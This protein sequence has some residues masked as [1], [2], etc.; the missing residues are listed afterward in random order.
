MKDLLDWY[1]RTITECTRTTSVRKGLTAVLLLVVTSAWA[2]EVVP[3]LRE[4]E[5]FLRWDSLVPLPLEVQPGTELWQVGPTVSVDWGPMTDDERESLA[6]RLDLVW[7]PLGRS[8]HPALASEAPTLR[9]RNL[10]S[11]AETVYRI[12]VSKAGVLIEGARA[13]DRYHAL[14]TLGQLLPVSARGRDSVTVLEGQLRDTAAWGWRGLML[15]SSRH[16][17]SVETVEWVLEL[18]ARHKLNR[19]HW[20]LTDDQGWRLPVPGW[21]LLT[22]VGGWRTVDGAPYGGF[23]TADEI[24]RVVAFAARRHIVVV[25]EVDL[26]GHASAA[27]AAYP[28]LSATGAP[29]SVPTEWG[30]ADGVL[31]IGRASVS[32]F[33]TDVLAALV[34]LFPGPWI[35]WGGDEVYR[36]PFLRNAES[37]AWMKKVKATTAE[38]ALAVF[39]ADLARKTL[40]AGKIPIGWDEVALHNPPQGTIVQWWDDPAR[41]L[42]A[43]RDGRPLIASW[44]ET[45]YLDYPELASDADR[46]TWMPLQTLDT[47]ATQPFLPPKAPASA[48]SLLLGIEAGLWSERAPETKLGRKLFP[49][50]A[51]VADLAWTGIVGGAPGWEERIE[52]HR[53]RLE[54]WGVGMPPSLR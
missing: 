30:V 11:D 10:E 38:Q 18:M 32:R 31:S 16:F 34:D 42:K 36:N 22:E 23:Y 8:W 54:S 33:T 45:S 46:A 6:E 49:R 15:D 43:L 3:D 50:L 28:E 17:P 2:G 19:F 35:H 26:P 13:E 41:A 53:R 44:K 5:E 14:V 20:H 27:L 29:R 51:L 39:W 40:A 4:S 24:R 47:V 7:G 25:P 37:L 48:R 52:A 12:E 1:K 9:F 21:P